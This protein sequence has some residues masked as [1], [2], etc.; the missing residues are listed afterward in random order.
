MTPVAIFSTCRSISGQAASNAASKPGTA[1]AAVKVTTV[2][3]DAVP[4]SGTCPWFVVLII[5]DYQASIMESLLVDGQNRYIPLP[6]SYY[7][8]IV[9]KTLLDELGLAL[10]ETSTD[11]L[12]I[13]SS[14]KE[15][16]L[17]V[18]ADG[19]GFGLADIGAT[20][21]CAYLILKFN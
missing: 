21:L 6:G 16:Q 18:T 1:D 19:F 17:G 20:F 12:G 14:A 10:P 15:R 3:P 2:F 9:N 8:Y 11:I 5:E 13:L 4:S 7:G